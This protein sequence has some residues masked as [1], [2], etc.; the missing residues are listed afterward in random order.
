MSERVLMVGGFPDAVRAA[1]I[2]AVD[3]VY[4]QEKSRLKQGEVKGATELFVGDVND[5]T[6]PYWEAILPRAHQIRPFT[7]AVSLTEFGLEFAAL[8]GQLQDL[9]AT[10]L[11]AVQSTRDKF[12]MREHMR[13][14]DSTVDFSACNDPA[15]MAEFLE[16]HSQVIVKPSK[17]TAS[18]HVT[19]AT[20]VADVF[21]HVDAPLDPRFGEWIM[22]EYVEGEEYSVESFTSHGKHTV[23]AIT[24]TITTGAPTFLEIG[25]ICP[26]VI[27]PKLRDEIERT[28]RAFLTVV[29]LDFGPA[30]TEVRVTPTGSVKI[31]ESQT[32]PGGDHISLLVKLA[33]GNDLYDLTIRELLRLPVTIQDGPRQTVAVEFLVPPE[34]QVTQIS[35]LEELRALPFIAESRINVRPGD[36]VRRP[37][38]SFTRN[39]GHLVV[40]GTSPGTNA[41]NV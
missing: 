4:L 29:S 31:I 36:T 23:L 20:N 21:R 35:G 27:D 2:Y 16:H 32:R 14:L 40:F 38:S 37:D 13:G 5:S 15:K 9:R 1:A 26:A 3:L 25:H 41:W 17:G 12:L 8:F 28:V 19:L 22:E 30:H 11:S 34:G 10:S 7:H 33:T 24:E 18:A 39:Y 6:W